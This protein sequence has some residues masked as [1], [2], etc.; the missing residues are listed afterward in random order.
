MTPSAGAP[1]TIEINVARKQFS[2]S[3][4]DGVNIKSRKL[5]KSA[6][7]AMSETQGFKTCVEAALFR[8]EEH[9]SELQSQR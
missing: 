3:L 4:R 7:T 6:I 2:S 1:N 9:T 5:G 8:S